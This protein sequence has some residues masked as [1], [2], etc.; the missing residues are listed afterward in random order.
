VI[1]S[2]L[3]ANNPRDREVVPLEP[4]VTVALTWETDDHWIIVA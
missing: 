3:D 1:N 2:R 4:L